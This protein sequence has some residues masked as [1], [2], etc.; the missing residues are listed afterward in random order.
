[1]SKN[2]TAITIA[3]FLMMTIAVTLVALP[4]ANAHD[5]PWIRVSHIYGDW[6]P[7]TIGV[8]QEVMMVW[9][10]NWIPQ[11]ARGAYGDRWKFTVTVTDPEGNSET[12]GPYT[13]DPVGGGYTYYTPTQVG[14]YTMVAHFPETVLLGDENTASDPDVGDIFLA[15]DSDPA[16]LTVVEEQVPRYVETPLPSGLWTRPIHGNNREWYVLAGNWLGSYAMQD[17]PTSNINAYS[18]APETSHILW[19][20]PYWAGGIADGY[21][22][23]IDYYG[24]QSYESYTGPNII[25]EG[26]IYYDVDQPPREGYYCVDLYTGETLYFH[27]TTGTINPSGGFD[28]SGNL[29]YG[30]PAYG[31]VLD[32]ET[33][34][35][36]GAFPYL[37]VTATGKSNTW[38]LLDGHTGNYICSIANV[39]SSGTMFRDDIGSICRINFRN[40][41]TSSN[42]NYYMQVWNTTESIMFQDIYGSVPPRSP[43]WPATPGISNTYWMWRPDFN[44]TFDGNNGFSMNVSVSSILGPRNSVLNETGSI[45]AVREGEMVIVGTNGRND[46]RGIA[47]GFLK[48]YSLERPD[49]GQVLWTK[50]FTPPKAMDDYPNNTYLGYQ[51]S[52]A[53]PLAGIS[54]EDGVFIFEERIT[55]KYYG[56]SLDTGK[57]IWET[58]PEGQWNFYGMSDFFYNGKFYGYGYTGVLWCYNITNGQRI[59][60]WT[61]P[62]EGLGESWYTNTPLS[63]ACIADGKGFFYTSEHSPNTPYRRDANVWCVDLET[64]KML[65]KIACWRTGGT[66][67]ADGRL[68][69]W[70][71]MD[72]SMYCVGK[73]SS[74]TT[75]SAS[76]DASVYGSSV[77]IKGTVTDQSPSGRHNVNGGLDFSLKGTPAIADEYMDAWMAY[78]FQQ[79]PKPTDA[80]GVEV[81]LETLDPNGNF[82]EIGNATSDINGNYGFAFT[83]DVPGTYQIIATFAGSGAYGG[84]SATTYL[85]VDEAPQAS[86]TAPPPPPSMADIYIVPGIVGIIIAIV[87]VGLVLVL[88]LRKR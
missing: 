41:G 36:H 78:M 51:Q 65:W 4:T 87:A 33:P 27:N 60:N 56:Y 79:R 86:P 70:N 69:F 58:K 63:L 15:G 23:D 13:S 73:G 37:W 67:I 42:P 57:Q 80:M 82:Y 25:L 17:G 77:M 83:P 44:A 10:S 38:N 8:N 9:W 21:F 45:R 64:G 1:M 46:A 12:M 28:Y 18:A 11:T 7:G 72:S 26:K 54:P 76:P 29:P 62:V 74:A 50:E 71:G 47:P 66:I 34:N 22:G 2:K 30:A 20:S 49:W 32:I 53:T 43:N 84:S 5:P 81:K 39:S 35:Q 85:T 16:Y 55:R 61:A 24:G 40:L 6:S 31:Q 19:T 3:L 59:W 88:M 68:V 14:T 52:S 48:A 75:V